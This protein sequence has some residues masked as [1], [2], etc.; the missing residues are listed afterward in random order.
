MSTSEQINI[1]MVDDQPSKLLSYETIL[2]DL[3][4]NL[5]RA[6]SAREALEQLLKTDIA[7]ILMDVSMP[8][9]DGFELAELIRQHPRYQKTAI[10]F[11]SAVH[12]TDFDQLKGYAAGAVD[13]VSVP[14]IPE[15]LR[16]KVSI[17][18]ELYRKTQQLERLNRELEQRVEERTAELHQRAE[19]LQRLN[20]E[21]ARSNQER[22]VLLERERDAR[23]QAE[24]AVRLRE[25]FLA[26]ASHELKTPLTALIGYGQTF[27][28]RARRA[29][30]LSER[31]ARSLERILAQA[32]RLHHM[33]NALL[34]V[35]RIEQ[36]RLRLERGMLDLGALACQTVAEIQTMSS[37]QRFD[38]QCPDTPLW[39][40]G[41]PLR[42]E[43]VLY[44]LLG[45]AMKYSPDGGPISVSITAQ[46]DT[47]SVAIRDEGIGIPARDLPHLFE[48]FFRASNVSVDNISGVGIGLYVVH[49]IVALHG[50]TV[51]V[52]SQEGHGS[53][54][55]ICLPR[56]AT[57]PN[58][59]GVHPDHAASP[60][61]SIA[62]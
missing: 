25:Q 34:D 38:I 21:L 8:E 10:I 23:A 17:F 62:H 20:A 53:T 49:E 37:Q 7:V 42:L 24:A 3:G 29:G 31:D 5:I 28:M 11:V 19:E 45:N 36:G 59:G 60:S 33:I 39:I 4:E 46:D 16:A 18:A 2:S 41:D 48:R 35:S 13:Y 57:L 15:I 14:V 1:L 47:V 26:I 22:Q 32:D 50:G 55:T 43:Q 56:D 44:N 9:I 54:F 52:E 61:H 27:Q 40:T 6:S 51:T 58:N 30:D 12:L